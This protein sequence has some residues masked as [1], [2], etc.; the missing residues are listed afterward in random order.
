MSIACGFQVRRTGFA[1]DLD[2]SFPGTGVTALFGPSG[3]GKST[4]L[5]CIAGL[6][7][8]PGRLT[9]NGVT[10]Q[11]A[12]RFVPVHRRPIGMVFQDPGLLPHRAVRSNLE[13]GWQRVPVAQRRIGLD[14]A[15]DLLGLAALLDRFPATQSGGE[16]PRVAIARALLT[17]PQLL[18]LD[19]P[20]SSLD[21][22]GAAI[23]LDHLDAVRRH[24]D[25]PILFVS[26]NVSEVVRLADHLV[27]IESGRVLAQGEIN[28]MLTRTDL[29][30][31]H[32]ADA[33]VMLEGRIAGHDDRFHLSLVDVPGGQLAVSRRP[34]AVGAPIRARLLARDLSLALAPPTQTS[35]Q[36]SLHAR[37]MELA[38]DPDPAQLLVR[39][40]L[41][42]AHC[43]ARV[44]RRAV[45]RLSLQPGM[46]VFLLVKSI[47]IADA[48][49]VEVNA[50]GPKHWLRPD[51]RYPG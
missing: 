9:V 41:G 29:P 25:I 3:A 6:E 51:C 21:Q 37:I 11:D 7:R 12:T 34:L 45:H 10:W 44:T 26:H 13:Y 27:L 49:G 39:L 32:H 4:L 17:S 8:H 38:D 28:A 16:R 35:I 5:R 46:A 23:I 30:L 43:L 42:T 33:G 19:E 20:L 24:L 2:V 14:D 31:A 22:A 1:L 47:A 48:P 15:I 36:N 18:L 50:I 40:D